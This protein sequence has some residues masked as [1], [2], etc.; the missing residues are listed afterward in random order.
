MITLTDLKLALQIPSATTTHDAYLEDLE[1]VAV[2]YVERVTGRYLGPEIAAQ[3][4]IVEGSGTASL[5]LP[6]RASAVTAVASRAYEGG[7]ET[8]IAT[9]D[10]DGWTLR[11]P[12][13]ATHGTRLIRKGG[14][15]WERGTEYKVTATIGYDET[16][17]ASGPNN[18]A[19]PAEDRGDVTSLV[20]HWFENRLP[21]VTGTVAAKV[22]THVADRLAARRKVR[23]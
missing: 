3:V 12:H 6:E 4:F 8:T 13:G 23:V 1:A 7:D 20:A 2:A 19:A 10:D 22:P 15:V 21:A 9:G 16:S 14:A 17:A 5:F 18:V 11:L